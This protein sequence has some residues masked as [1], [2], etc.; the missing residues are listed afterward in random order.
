M[1]QAQERAADFEQRVGKLGGYPARLTDLEATHAAYVAGKNEEDVKCKARIAELEPLAPKVAELEGLVKSKDAEIAEHVQAHGDKDAR[2]ASLVSRIAELEPAARRVPLLEEQ[3]THHMDAHADRD[4]H[5]AYL[6]A[7]VEDQRATL[8]EKD[9]Q[10]GDL[11]AL[12]NRPQAAPLAPNDADLQYELSLVARKLHMAETGIAAQQVEIAKLNDQLLMQK[13]A[14]PARAPLKA[15]AAA[16]GA[17][18]AA[19]IGFYDVS[20]SSRAQ[21]PAAVSATPPDRVL[22]FEKRIEELRNLETS[23][24]DEIAKLRSRITEIEESP[25]PDVRRQILLR[26]KN[27]ELTHMRGVLNSLLQPVNQEDVAVRAYNYA[28]ERGFQGGSE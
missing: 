14:Q 22:E 18:S 4:A 23:K 20:E 17:G 15:M 24:D 28:Q 1:R 21:Q 12:V 27:A 8:V 9:E 5:I 13:A 6:N 19:A 16:A 7:E 2:L 3:I 25:D 10:I 26:A 11:T